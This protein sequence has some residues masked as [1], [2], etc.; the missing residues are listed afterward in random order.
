VTAALIPN[1]RV[2]AAN[3]KAGASGVKYDASFTAPNGLRD[4]FFEGGTKD[5]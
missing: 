4:V 3:N 1:V 2:I 5:G